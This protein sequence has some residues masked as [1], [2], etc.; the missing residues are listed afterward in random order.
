MYLFKL[1]FSPGNEFECSFH[2]KKFACLLCA[3]SILII[4]DTAVNKTVK[5]S[6]PD[7]S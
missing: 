6:S 3:S 5:N 2:K 1:W 4:K 7:K